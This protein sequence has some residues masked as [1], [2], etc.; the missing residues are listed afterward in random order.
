LANVDESDDMDCELAK[1]GTDD[2]DV[3]D[4]VLR[5]LFG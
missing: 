3:E 1:D 2:V 4:I 5:A